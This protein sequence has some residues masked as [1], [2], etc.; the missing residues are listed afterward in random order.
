MYVA[1]E[2]IVENRTGRQH[3]PY[4]S[5]EPYFLPAME[6]QKPKQPPQESTKDDSSDV[7]K[8][9]QDKQGP[10]PEPEPQG[11]QADEEEDEEAEKGHS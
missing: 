1:A 3:C 11:S 8:V 9:R 10:P 4:M 5:T 7:E 2:F 6:E